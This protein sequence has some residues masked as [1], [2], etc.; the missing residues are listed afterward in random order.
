[1]VACRD[2]G[3]QLPAGIVRCLECGGSTRTASATALAILAAVA[4]LAAAIYYGWTVGATT[5]GILRPAFFFFTGLG[6]LWAAASAFQGRRAG[7]IGL[8]LLWIASVLAP[9]A[10]AV[11]RRQ[12]ITASLSRDGIEF[13]IVKLPI[14]LGIPI[15]WMASTRAYCSA[16]SNLMTMF[17]RE[18]GSYL[19][20]PLAYVILTVFLLLTGIFYYFG[21]IQYMADGFFLDMG[22]ERIF[23]SILTFLIFCA[24]ILTMRLLAEEKRSG[25]IEVLLTAPVTDWQIVLAKFLAVLAF[26]GILVSPTLAYVFLLTRY[27]LSTPDYGLIAGGYVGLTF[28]ACLY[29]SL[30]LFISSLTRS[31]IVAAIISFVCFVTLW[32]LPHAMSEQL[33]TPWLRQIFEHMNFVK[34]HEVFVRG[35]IDSRAVLF[36]VSLTLFFL[37]LTVRA[38]E[39]RRWA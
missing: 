37:F 9:L 22:L 26:F 1:M 21:F 10:Y 29:F 23:G 30:G 33:G 28:M 5:G 14:L 20:F 31:Q 32:F 17:R 39:S 11:L 27:S 8:Q 3:R 6:L 2:C 36:D 12:D 7:W 19:F 38:M 15:A 35:V 13:L 25:T 24:P 18:L 34:Y 4:G 16:P